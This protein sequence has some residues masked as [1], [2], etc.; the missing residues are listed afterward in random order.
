MHHKTNQQNKTYMK[1]IGGIRKTEEKNNKI[2]KSE[3][4]KRIHNQWPVWN[5]TVCDEEQMEGNTGRPTTRP[6][7]E[8]N[9]D[10][11]GSF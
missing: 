7:E 9:V 11:S 4:T 3:E 6:C 10:Y 8:N 5:V 1:W 2:L